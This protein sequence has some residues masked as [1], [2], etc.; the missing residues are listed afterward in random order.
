VTSR[1]DA[2]TFVVL[3]TDGRF[4]RRCLDAVVP[5]M[6]PRDRVVVLGAAVPAAHR[7]HRRL[8]RADH[9]GHDLGRYLAR[10]HA[11]EAVVVVAEQTIL[12]GT[13]WVRPLRD[14]LAGD[15][16]VVAVP[17]TN[18]APWPQCPTDPPDLDADLAAIQEVA[19]RCATT[20]GGAIGSDPQPRLD[21]PGGPLCGLSPAA[22][23]RLDGPLLAP[24][25]EGLARLATRRG[26]AVRLLHEVY[27]HDTV[28]QPL[29]SAALIVKNEIDNIDR[30][31]A[32]L[33]GFVDE[34]VV[35]DTGSTDGTIERARALG[36]VVVE[37]EWRDDFAWARNE[38]LR[39]CR[40]TWVVSLDADEELEADVSVEVLRAW[41]D[42]LRPEPVD[43][44]GLWLDNLEGSVHAPVRSRQPNII[45]RLFRRRTR[46]WVGAL[47]EQVVPRSG[48]VK[49]GQFLTENLRILHRGYL[50]E[51]IAERNKGERNLRIVEQLTAGA[52]DQEPGKAEF[53]HARTLML[54]GRPADSIPLFEL[55][56]DLAVN[57]VYRRAA[58][59]LGA[60]NLVDLDRFDDA[61]AWCARLRAISATDG[62]AR[63]LEATVA[64]RRKDGATA[65]ALLDGITDYNDRFSNNP[66]DKL[67]VMRA[68]AHHYAD[69]PQGCVDAAFDAL[70]RNPL[71][72]DAWEL[73]V[74]HRAQ[75]A[76]ALA[77]AATL[78]RADQLTPIVARTLAMAPH[79]ADVLCEALWQAHPQAMPI[80]AAASHAAPWL[81]VADA[82]RWSERL[83]RL[84]LAS[85]CPLEAIV[86][87]TGRPVADRGLAAAHLVDLLDGDERRATLEHLVGSLDDTT[88]TELLGQVLAEAPHAA[89]SVVVAGT[90]SRARAVGIADVLA[91]HGFAGEAAAVLAAG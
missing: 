37:G 60:Q 40:G 8:T 82:R 57:P 7:S 72:R 77:R 5:A 26:A 67:A 6:G 45:T 71:V 50:N 19:R 33:D 27:A 16:A 24:D 39:R 51:V 86:S 34:V 4:V 21:R 41:L 30:C 83:R 12:T 17:A 44:L 23:A 38:A 13:K 89:D 90:T 66:D 3:T 63:L 31:I 88:L 78:T 85:H 54:A 56:H 35:Y 10:A 73:L 22:V 84:G 55:A 2:L 87:V 43:A 65:L 91:R 14:A 32:S 28:A 70:E 76:Q 48:D 58:L 18:G 62:V 64:L 53:D 46:H 61:L 79:E 81:A 29:V 47:H 36:A 80:A 69:D 9:P 1:S 74:M 49:D 25:P 68:W 59:E 42:S 75:A 52:D 15:A 20:P 11:D